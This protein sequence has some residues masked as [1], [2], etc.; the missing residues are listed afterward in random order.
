MKRWITYVTMLSLVLSPVAPVAVAAAPPGDTAV[1]GGWPRAFT[2]PSGATIILYQPQ[3]GSW[4]DQKHMTIFAAVS[5]Q[6]KDKTM[7][8]V[9]ALK[10]EADTSVALA[11]RLVNF[12]EFE[13]TTAS[14]PS[15]PKDDV[16]VIVDDIL[17]AVPR[18]QRVIGLDR[19]LAMVDT[20]QVVPKNA[21][22][23]KADPP[24]IFFSDAPAVLVNLDGPAIWSPIPNTDLRFAVNTNWDLFEYREAKSY[25]LRVDKSWMVAESV[26]GPWRRAMTLPPIFATLP[27]DGNWAEVREGEGL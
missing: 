14:F 24:P 23:V 6:A 18:D 13:I 19:V 21:A 5:H 26:D 7:P 27:D 9:G 20:S 25:Y 10:I 8:S 22:G 17:A 15:V 12:S 3:V 1:D 2:A 16:K 4:P 11:E